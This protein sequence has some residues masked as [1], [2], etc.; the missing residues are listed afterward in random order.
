MSLA[1]NLPNLEI[2][3]DIHVPL[4]VFQCW[5]IYREL[6]NNWKFWKGL[7]D[8]G[9][10]QQFGPA[11]YLARPTDQFPSARAP[12]VNA[13]SSSDQARR[14]SHVDLD[15]G[16]PS[17]PS[18]RA[19]ERR[20]RPRDIPTASKASMPTAPPHDAVHQCTRH[21]PAAI[22]SPHSPTWP[23]TC[24]GHPPRSHLPRRRAQSRRMHATF[25]LPARRRKLPISHC[26]SFPISPMPCSTRHR[27][28]S[29]AANGSGPSVTRSCPRA[30]ASSMS[31]FSAS[32]AIHQAW[33]H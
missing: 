6:E 7:N 8:R 25:P 26:S 14:H 13:E 11:A 28:A 31:F 3:R 10:L 32:Q 24:T 17:R 19:S 2:F 18:C 23:P 27:G 4:F 21:G 9:P 12:M 29:F 30:T 33:D 1:I 5:S 22:T 20:C 15:R 16:S